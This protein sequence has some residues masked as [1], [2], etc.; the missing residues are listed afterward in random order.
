MPSKKRLPPKNNSP[1]IELP[2]EIFFQ[3]VALVCLFFF[4]ILLIFIKIGL[5]LPLD[6]GI[7]SAARLIHSPYINYFLVALVNLTSINNSIYLVIIITALLLLNR[8]YHQTIFLLISVSSAF[9]MEFIIKILVQRPR[10]DTALINLSDFS[11]PSGHSTISILL[12]VF[13]IYAFKDDIKNKTL[14][15][16]FIIFCIFSFLIVGFSRIY[17][18]VHWFTDVLA[19]FTLGLFCFTLF[20]SYF[21]PEQK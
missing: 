5:T 21:H 20:A 8:R 4:I 14:K 6:Q 19:G 7:N 11:F 15:Y 10:P 9:F 1:Q 13:L 18:N 16:I 3:K 2:K 12:F 17:I